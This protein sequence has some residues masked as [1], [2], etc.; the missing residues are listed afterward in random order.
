LSAGLAKSNAALGQL[1]RSGPNA[2]QGLRAV[3]RGAQLLAFQAAGLTGPLGRVSAGLLQLGGGN[4]LVLGA[5]AGVGAIA[6]AYSALTKESREAAEAQQKLRDE[7]VRTAAARS[8]A[9]VPESQKIGRDVSTTQDELRRLQGER[10]ARVTFLTSIQNPMSESLSEMLASDKQIRDLDAD[11][12]AFTAT[13]NVNRREGAKATHDELEAAKK[14]QEVERARRLEAI[15]F[16]MDARR[17]FV[18]NALSRNALFTAGGDLSGRAFLRQPGL[19]T[20]PFGAGG[21]GLGGRPATFDTLRTNVPR[22]VPIDPTAK[23]E[24]WLKSGQIIAAGF[25]Q[26]VTAFKAGGPG[27]VAG[28]FG[29]LFSAG[30]QIPGISAGLGKTL[31]TVGFIGSVLG[32]V[33]TLF[34]HSA[35]RRQREQME[36]LRRIRENTDKRGRPDH[37]SVTVLLNGKEVSASILGDV[38]YG[39]RR[40]ERTN[41]V[42]VLPPS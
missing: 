9:R 20:A 3:E 42:P 17:I 12:A 21:L 14:L 36:E 40:M 13:I 24:D 26:A 25:F 6:F 23:K 29:A 10:A 7:I 32:T 5:V 2:G 4:A 16:N 33:F 30:A 11:I 18:A 41:A 8:E 38:I 27:G 15:Q 22:F 39:I 35:E 31:G 19:S 37:I 34:D 28:G 1:A